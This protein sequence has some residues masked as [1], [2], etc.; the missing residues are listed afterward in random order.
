MVLEVLPPARMIERILVVGAGQMGGG[1]AQVAATA[2]LARRRSSTVDEPSLE[3]G[4]ARGAESR[5]RACTRR[6][7]STIPRLSLARISTV[8]RA[9]VGT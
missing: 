6:A 1:I 5:S 3:R 2:G 4:L 9:R 7:S 8:H